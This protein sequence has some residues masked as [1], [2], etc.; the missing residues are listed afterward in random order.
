[1]VINIRHN[2]RF[3]FDLDDT[4]T[5]ELDFVHSGFRHIAKLLH[6]S[7]GRDISG[8]MITLFA[9]K[10]N[11]FEWVISTFTPVVPDLTLERLLKEYREHHPD[12]SLRPDAANLL[13]QLTA[14]NVPCGL[15]TDGRSITQRNKL[16]ALNLAHFFTDE[17]ISEEFGSEKPD[18][19]NYLFFEEKYPGSD[20][21]FFGDNTRKDFLIPLKLGWTCICVKDRGRN[22]HQQSFEYRTKPHYIINS[23]DDVSLNRLTEK[24]DNRLIIR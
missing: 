15:I 7:L 10:K 18:P 14:L 3:V 11:V 17:I 22:I 9:Q 5:E 21:Y 24:S 19:A 16:K 4:L 6:M 13:S 20:F 8:D 2:T 23:F 12:I 1:M